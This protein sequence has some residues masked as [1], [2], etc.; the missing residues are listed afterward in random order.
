M[1]IN[2]GGGQNGPAE[3]G[4]GNKET[5][6]IDDV[7]RGDSLHLGL[8][9]GKGEGPARFPFSAEG[10][11]KG[12]E[13]QQG[14]LMYS[15]R[16]GRS[17]LSRSSSPGR[18]HLRRRLGS[19]LLASLSKALA[20]SFGIFAVSFTLAHLLR[21]LQEASS[22]L[23]SI[24][25]RHRAPSSGGLGTARTA[26]R[27]SSSSRRL[28]GVNSEVVPL[29]F[30]QQLG[31]PPLYREF[32][33]GDSEPLPAE[34]V[35]WEPPPS[36]HEAAQVLRGPPP[37]YSE[38]CRVFLSST[39][40]LPP[41]SDPEEDT[42]LYTSA[43]RGGSALAGRVSI[44]GNPFLHPFKILITFLTIGAV[45]W[46]LHDLGSRTA[47]SSAGVPSQNSTAPDSLHNASAANQSFPQTIATNTS[48]ATPLSPNNVSVT[49]SH[50][51]QSNF[52]DGRRAP[53]GSHSGEQSF[54]GLGL[55]IA[56]A[57]VVLGIILTRHS[58]RA[59]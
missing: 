22:S 11:D 19:H 46:L 33:D 48:A 52:T 36:Y 16:R 15:G 28:A 4:A 58:R 38:Q 1:Q 44:V 35:A 27:S 26:N 41:T 39:T 24:G 20:V 49:L 12:E 13:E 29:Q 32:S 5:G 43:G 51:L 34:A 40:S 9:N 10:K 14:L 59:A 25:S 3:A 57:V 30:Y 31:P 8:S 45:A 47:K 55:A 21:C 23:H 18:H 42:E 53:S 56:A 6:A 37:P 2:S 54:I 7:A 17:V 50:L